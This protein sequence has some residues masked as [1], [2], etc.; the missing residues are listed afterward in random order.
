MS[1]EQPP[2]NGRKK[3]ESMQDPEVQ[4][5]RILEQD[6]RLLGV[7]SELSMRIRALPPDPEY[8]NIQPRALLVGGFVRDS[9]LGLQPKDLDVEVYGVS[10][11]RLKSV[12]EQMYPGRVKDIGRAF[13]VLN[14]SI[15]DDIKFDVSVPRRDSKTGPEHTDFVSV[16]DPSMTIE[17]AARRRDFSMNSIA[18]DL[19]TGETFD[20]F[21]GI[22]DIENK[23]LRVT[24]P[25]Q[26]Q[27]DALRVYR[28]TQFK[29]RM[30][31][32]V[33]PQTMKL[34][35][36]M[37][38]QGR[39]D[40]LSKERVYEEMC[41]LLEKSPQPSIGFELMRELG[42]V[43]KYYPELHALIDVPQEP[44]WHPEG[45]VWIHTMMVVDAAAK[46]I[47]QENRG[48]TDEEK[49]EVMF[50]ALC[51]DLGKPSTTAVSKK[52]GV[53]RIRSLGHEEAGKE[54]TRS[55]L[56]RWKVSER[57][58]RAA[59]KVAM[60]HLKPGMLFLQLQKGTLAQS[61]YNNAVRKLIRR[62][63]PTT[64]RV[65]LAAS[66]ADSRGRTVP[67]VQT[68]P[69]LPGELFT[70]T[71]EQQQLDVEPTK[72]LLQ[73]RDLMERGIPPGKR[74]GAFIKA[75]EDA[76]DEGKIITREEAIQLLD[77]L[78]AHDK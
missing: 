75:V 47:R 65:L 62:I 43:E 60:E 28:A 70:Q 36:E 26:F 8:P 73:G 16:G 40:Y 19:V 58:E 72:P 31:L 33:E 22:P 52:D 30:D 55:L 12:L 18:T 39:L 57:I 41:K 74:I 77:M 78:I 1:A 9:L 6:P 17:E 13:P 53:E 64:W 29:A 24:D 2:T 7:A 14:I 59:V 21:I 27:E 54:P 45:D 11:A 4:R 51:H 69:Y 48:F 63:H 20:P 35:K 44:E 56:A 67:G 10:A 50:G 49:L 46:I 71:V 61:G 38:E 3:H 37:V 66:E 5:R 25:K 34:M 68:D 32:S 42:I 15:A 23:I 76:R